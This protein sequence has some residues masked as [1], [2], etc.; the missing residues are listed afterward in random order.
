MDAA[1]MREKMLC[2][3]ELVMLELGDTGIDKFY[4]ISEKCTV[5]TS[6]K[7]N[8][9]LSEGNRGNSILLKMR[10]TANVKFRTKYG[11]TPEWCYLA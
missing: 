5:I 6:K 4:E 10:H 2:L 8:T 9:F 1:V 7:S 3:I 11:I